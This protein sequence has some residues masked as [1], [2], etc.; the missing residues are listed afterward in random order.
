MNRRSP[1]VP[2]ADDSRGRQLVRESA[3]TKDFVDRAR[4]AS[5]NGACDEAI[6]WYDRALLT[7]TRNGASP[8]LADVLRWKGTVHAECGDTS[9]ADRLYRESGA[10]AVSAGYTRGE[11]HALNCRATIAQRRG[12]LAVAE[13]LYHQA[14]DLATAANDVR[15][16]AMILRNLGIVASIRGHLDLAVVR[17]LDSYEKARE[18]GD[19]DGQCR[20]LNNVATTYM[21]SGR[22]ADA[23]LTY[24]SAI[25][26][27]R[28][29]GDRATECGCRINL[30]EAMI[31]AGKLADAE[32]ECMAAL[33]IADWRGDRLRRAEGLKV[34]AIIARHRGRDHEA[35][36]LLDE[37]FDLTSAGE[38]AVL[39]AQLRQEKAEIYRMRRSFG[40]AAKS[41]NEARDIFRRMG[42]SGKV[43][44]IDR[45]M[46]KMESGRPSGPAAASPTEEP[47]PPM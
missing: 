18:I 17:F 27:A 6:G 24:T 37:A 3:E 8:D 9:E 46:A 34:L 26:L 7:L 11:A 30:C 35:E 15:L 36:S 45:I 21:E 38:D 47:I 44:E 33:G 42:A 19:E 40:M 29:R 28:K 25:K 10:I 5:L 13:S 16:C 23:E 1:D 39:A 22:Y 4:R 2:P 12:E 31:G 41:F 43:A 14:N 20:A 32:V